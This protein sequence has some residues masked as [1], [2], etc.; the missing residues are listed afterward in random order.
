MK[1]Q[2][3]GK[4]RR[5]SANE[6]SSRIRRAVGRAGWLTAAGWLLA[7]ASAFGMSSPGAETSLAGELRGHVTVLAETIGPRAAFRGDSLQRAADYIVQQFERSGWQPRRQA[8]PVSGVVC[9]NI[10]VERRGATR[11]DEI[12]IVGAHYDSVPVTPGADDNASGV[13]A[14][15]RLAKEFA[16]AKNAPGRTL[17]FVAFANEEPIY[18]QTELMGSRVYARECK[19]R[20]EKI[21]AMLSLES[22]GYFSSERG[23]QRYPS[24]FLGWIYP[25]RGDF[26]AIVGNRSSREL[27]KRVSRSFEAGTRLPSVSA[28]LPDKMQGIGWSDHWSFWQEGYPAVMVTDTAVFRNPHYH[29]AT[30]TPDTLDY[31][32]LASAVNGLRRVV[33]D[34]VRAP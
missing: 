5:I 22:I 24:A 2:R 18:F 16:E 26:L 33:A 30:D 27:V 14:L 25:S 3:A 21:V 13:A 8:Y 34:L 9:E 15:L 7:A 32:A 20:G 17:R 1:R 28:A 11:P 29:R 4:G 19:K 31:D 6:P 10:E 12:V 23:T